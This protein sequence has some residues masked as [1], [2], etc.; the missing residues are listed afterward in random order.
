MS[1]KSEDTIT[2]QFFITTKEIFPLS[3][4]VAKTISLIQKPA[5]KVNSCG[6]IAK[7]FG[8]F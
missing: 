4:A 6:K 1:D 5:G 3:L 8:S 7:M 2:E